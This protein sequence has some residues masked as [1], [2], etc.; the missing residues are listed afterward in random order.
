MRYCSMVSLVVDAGDQAFV[1][2]VQQRHAGRL[3]DAAALGLD[4]PVLDL[5]AHAKAMP[6]ADGVGLE[7]QRDGIGERLAVQRDGLALL[8][9]HDDLFGLD[10]TVVAPERHAHD[11]I[12]DLDAAVEL[13]EIL[14]LVGCTEQIAV[15]RV[16]LFGAHLVGES[17]GGHERRHFRAAAQF[18]DELLVEPGLVD[19]A[20]SDWSAG[21]SGRTA[22]YRCLCRWSHR[23]R[24]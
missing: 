21:R 7:E 17:I 11:R 20:G 2:D 6:A 18:V 16:G 12:D 24:C 4:D 14:G 8:K 1:G 15:G 10:D 19:L 23:P 13:L 5:V 9:T 22:R 3:V